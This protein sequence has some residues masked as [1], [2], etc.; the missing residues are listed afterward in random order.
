MQHGSLTWENT[1]YQEVLENNRYDRGIQGGESMGWIVGMQRAINYVEEH[2]KERLDYEEIAK[3]ADC[4]SYYFQKIFGILCDMS[5]GEYI[6]NRRLSLAGSEL[7]GTDKKVIDI[8]LEYGYESPE[9]FTRAFVKFHGV[10]PT[11][12]RTGEKGLK[13]FSRIHVE[14][15]MKG[16]NL[17]ENYKIVEKAAFKVLEKVETHSISR[18]ANKNTIPDFWDRAHRDGTVETLIKQTDDRTFIYGICYGNTLE[19]SQTF[20]YAIAAKYTQGAEI[21]EGFRVNEIPARTWLVFDCTGPMPQAIQDTFHR[22]ITEFFP[23]SEYEPTFEF[24]I[25]AYP[26][27][28]MTT[29][30]YKSQVWIPI[31][32]A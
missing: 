14:I 26:A 23:S 28:P 7:V 17:M 30:D 11:Q 27:G 9:S 29:A 5:L 6:R 25:E 16:G 2:L 8:A 12:A 4:S 10:T 13:I 1:K 18:E 21:P 32:N 3:Q 20:E 31:K 24:D 22:I 15:T 19:D